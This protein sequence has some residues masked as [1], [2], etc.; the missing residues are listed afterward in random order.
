MST[1]CFALSVAAALLLLHA[2]A[3]HLVFA[4]A[5]SRP[6]PPSVLPERYPSVTMI[7]PVKGEDPGQMENFRAALDHGYPGEVETIFA[8]DDERDPGFPNAVRAVEEHRRAGGGGTARVITT[9]HPPDGVTGKQNAM[10]VAFAEAGGELVGFGDS[11]SRPGRQIL[12]T[13]V[14]TLLADA[15]NGCTFA[16]VVI[17]GAYLRSGDVAYAVML[18]AFYGSAAALAAGRDGILPFAMGQIMLFRRDALEAIGGLECA[19][20]QLVDDMHLGARVDEA[21]FRNIMIAGPLPII[22]GGWSLS[23]WLPVCRRWLLFTRNGLRAGFL[24]PQWA[25]GAGYFASLALALGAAVAGLAAPAA[26]AGAAVAFH[27]WSVA[28]LH[29]RRGA[30]PIPVWAWWMPW[31]LYLVW[32]GVMLTL[33]HPRVRWRGR[34]YRLGSSARLKINSREENRAA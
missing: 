16:P 17:P 8:F 15:R 30:P 1:L 27:G 22:T 13:L 20:G 2:A 10:I 25:S 28:D 5:M 12:R 18:N 4:R 26:L 19:R 29:R 21:G 33:V 23:R 6:D 11:D 9:G 3:W 7:R 32:A 34:S 31:G 24:W 14:E